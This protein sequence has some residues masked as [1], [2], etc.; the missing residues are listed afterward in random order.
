MTNIPILKLKVA[1]RKSVKLFYN[2]TIVLV[3]LLASIS[4]CCEIF[5]FSYHVVYVSLILFFLIK[6]I[7]LVSWEEGG[8]KISDSPM[9]RGEV[10]VGGYS[11]TKGY[12]NNEAKTNEVYKVKDLCQSSLVVKYN[13]FHFNFC[14]W[15]LQVDER[16]MRWF[17]TGDIGQF[18]PDGCLEIIDRKK[19]IVK[20]QHGEYV[21]LGKVWLQ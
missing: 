6:W 8:Y 14:F 7:Q 10:V 3:G 21:S 9:P 1:H 12:F 20:L 17:Y 19:D 16:G 15:L 18:H 5:L 2:T 11:I 4:F 13:I